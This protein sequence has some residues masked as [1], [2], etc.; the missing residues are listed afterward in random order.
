MRWLLKSAMR[1]Y[2]ERVRQ[3]GYVHHIERL[4]VL[5][6]FSTLAGLHPISVNNWF[7]STFVDA[8]E[9]VMVCELHQ[10]DERL[11]RELSF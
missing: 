8:Y 2:A 5:A 11:L 3:D 6:N 9:W 10:T 7:L 4:M 1:H